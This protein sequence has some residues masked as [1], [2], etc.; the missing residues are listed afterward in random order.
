MR[1]MMSIPDTARAAA[2]DESIA[3]AGMLTAARVYYLSAL[4]VCGED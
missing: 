1:G 2:I 4:A 3:V